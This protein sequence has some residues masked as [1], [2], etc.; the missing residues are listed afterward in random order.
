M[1][2]IAFKTLTDKIYIFN[3][4]LKK[5]KKNFF[6]QITVHKSTKKKKNFLRL[7]TQGLS[8]T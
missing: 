2:L 7:S 4:A 8:F 1:G 3:A 6:S 5:N